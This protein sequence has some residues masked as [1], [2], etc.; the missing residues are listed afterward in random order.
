MKRI[1]HVV[2]SLELGGT[3]AFI[4]NHYR[5][6]NRQ[7]IQFDFLVCAKKD[8]PYL[9]EIDR[10]GGRV[11]YTARPSILRLGSFLAGMKQA[12]RE[13]GP[14]AAI[15]CHADA[16]NAVPIL[17]GAICGVKKRIAHLHAIDQMPERWSRK[18]FHYV[19]KW[20]IKA[21]ATDVWACSEE[22]GNSFVG[23]DYFGKNG[24]VIRN[25]ISLDRFLFVDEAHKQAL[26]EEFH[27][28]DDQPVLGNITRFDE[29]KNQ[30]FLVEVFK[31]L[32]TQHPEALLILGG[33]DGG[34][35]QQV[36]D[37]VAENDLEKNVRFIGRRNDVPEWLS[38][39]DVYV[40]P[41]VFEGL[42]I[43]LLEAQAAGCLCVASTG[44][45]M[46][47]DMGLGTAHYLPLSEGAAGWAEF[48]SAKLDKKQKPLQSDIRKAFVEK[49]FDINE[50][51]KELVKYYG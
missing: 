10:L 18:W 4:M 9:K 28:S 8:W 36:K 20:L 23:A 2:P 29:N 51:C 47:T 45:P 49:H 48:L 42:G 22:A 17:C 30:L 41:S 13:G 33:T 16:D 31:N 14:Y 12:I 19:K 32:L 40:F 6:M 38:L 34:K 25:G 50:S 24:K 27:I 1:L 5:S 11:F 21:F 46:D 26:K 39:M 35:L 43:A 15:H 37:Y 3:E 44:V 7:E